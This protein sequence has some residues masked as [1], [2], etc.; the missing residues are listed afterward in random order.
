MPIVV[1]VS[2]RRSAVVARLLLAVGAAVCAVAI[3]V[4]VAWVYTLVV[5]C[6]TIRS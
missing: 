2:C 4:A 3:V 5:D 1:V 6:W